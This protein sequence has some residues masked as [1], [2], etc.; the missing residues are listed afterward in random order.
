MRPRRPRCQQRGE[1]DHRMDGDRRHAT[2]VKAVKITRLITRGLI[3]A[4][5][6]AE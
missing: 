3:S 4:K 5:I 1:A 2:P 6:V